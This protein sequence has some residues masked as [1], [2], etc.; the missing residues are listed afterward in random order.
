M[1]DLS[2][3][4]LL[5]THANCADGIA[6]AMVATARQKIP[7]AFCNYGDDVHRKWKPAPDILWVD[8]T[9]HRDNVEATGTIPGMCIDHHSEVRD[10]CERFDSHIF[11][12]EGPGVS[13]CALL[14]EAVPRLSNGKAKKRESAIVRMV[15]VYDS[16]DTSNRGWRDACAMA[17][18]LKSWPIEDLLDYAWVRTEG[19]VDKLLD[20]GEGLVRQ[21]ERRLEALAKSAWCSL[22]LKNK[23]V[24]VQADSSDT[25]MLADQLAKEGCAFV[26]VGFTAMVRD[27]SPGYL[28][29]LRSAVA[30]DGSHKDVGAIATRHG[31]GGHP[32]SAGCWV[33]AGRQDPWNRILEVL[34]V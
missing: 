16:W 28:L 11:R 32:S 20:C 30:P 7:V 10:I 17:A 18:A 26:T 33:G 21:Q 27:G 13:G 5:V 12:K 19:V 2:R 31:G 25:S 8:M 14:L 24:I 23:I 22:N 6:A 9:P 4:N 15:S 3:F 34:G 29:S 1:I